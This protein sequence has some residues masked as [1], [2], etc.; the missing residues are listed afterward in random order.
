MTV[1]F[2]KESIE[3]AKKIIQENWQIYAE[4]WT[5]NK[6]KITCISLFG[7]RAKGTNR[8]DSDA[9]FKCVISEPEKEL[10]INQKTGEKTILT[11]DKSMTTVTFHN[12]IMK[13]VEVDGISIDVFIVWRKDDNTY[14]SGDGIVAGHKKHR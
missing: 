13:D 5:Y 1:N 7:S 9:D 6:P 10:H 8:P 11:H 2:T 3:R 12:Y 14:F 4:K